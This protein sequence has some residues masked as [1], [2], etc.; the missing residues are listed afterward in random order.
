MEQLNSNKLFEEVRKEKK[1]YMHL[2][3]SERVKI[4]EL[5]KSGNS[6]YK[7]AKLI[8]RSPSTIYREISKNGEKN[9][10]SLSSSYTRIKKYRYSSSKAQS[11]R[12]NRFQRAK[13]FKKYKFFIQ[14]VNNNIKFH[15]T[16]E[17]LHS[18]FTK[19][20]PTY[21][22]PTLKT[23]YNWAHKDIITYPWGFNPVKKAKKR[24]FINSD[25]LE[26]RK[27]ISLREKDFNFKTNNYEF[28]KHFEID[29]IYNG[30]KKGGVLTFNERATRKLYAVQIPN[31]K[32]STIN[33]ALRNMINKIGSENI[34]SITSDNGSE[35]AYSK[36]IEEYYSLKWYYCDP[37]CSYQRGQNERLNRD[38]RKFYPKGIL[39]TNID[40]ESFQNTINII[41][42]KPRRILNKL[43]A[44]E[45]SRRL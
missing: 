37:Y 9:L 44:N 26:D 21:D 2:S 1:I 38:I 33:K 39:I 17:D 27:S 6:C 31:R 29:T 5:Y 41:N 28:R 10:V 43:S 14:E 23:M 36:V 7:I 32:A 3:K 15:T 35:F 30:D 8:S 19:D 42:N 20:Y 34:L 16:L 24:S 22:C 13:N 18:Q 4:A 40:K 25:N 12:N 11:K 45:Y